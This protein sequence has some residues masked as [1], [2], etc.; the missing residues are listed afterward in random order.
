MASDGQQQTLDAIHEFRRTSYQNGYR[1]LEVY[2]PGALDRDG[3][4]IPSAG[5]RPVGRKWRE[6][7]L[8]NPPAAVVRRVS[9][10]ATNT[11]IVTGELSGLDVDV[12]NQEITDTIVAMIEATLSPTPLSRIGRAPKILLCY[13]AEQPFAKL[14]TPKYRL[15]DGTEAQL[16]ILGDGQQFVA[17]GIHPDTGQPFEWPDR[18]PLDVPLA[19]LP[20]ISAMQ[21]RDIV[22]HATSILIEAGGIIDKPES[23][24]SHGGRS[25]ESGQ[26]FRAVNDAALADIV[27]WAPSLGFHDRGGNSGWR[28]TSKELGR[29]L[30]ED[31]SIHPTGIWDFG[32]EKPL[33]AID[34]V[35]AHGGAADAVQA[36]MWLCERLGKDPESLGWKLAKGPAPAPDGRPG[37]AGAPGPSFR[38]PWEQLTPP[39]WPGG[40]LPTRFE[41][42]IA[43]M[44]E[45]SGIDPGAVGIAALLA[46]SGAAPKNCRL[47]PYGDNHSFVVP[48]IL[49]AM[50]VAPSGQRK[51]YLNDVFVA[52][53]HHRDEAW[54]QY[55]TQLADWN[56]L[57][58]QSKK[59]TPKPREP[60]A[61]LVQDITPEKM[62]RMLA[63][64]DRGTLLQRDELAAFFGFGR[65]ANDR[66]TYERSLYLE[67]YDGNQLL[68]QRLTHDAAYVRHCAVA[69][70]GSIQP[71]RLQKLNIDALGEDGLLQRFIVIMLRKA[72]ISERPGTN[73]HVTIPGRAEFNK[74]VGKLLDLG[75]L[76]GREFSATREGAEIVYRLEALGIALGD[77]TDYGPVFPEFCAKL[78]GTA[79]RLAFVLHMLDNPDAGMKIV[80]PETIARADRL[81][82]EYVLPHAR[83]F[84]AEMSE[85]GLERTRAIAAWLLA[86]APDRITASDFG[87]HV[88]L[89]RGLPLRVLNTALD[90][91]VGGGWLV[92]ESPYPGNNAWT[93][94]TQ[95]RKALAHRVADATE[96]RERNRQLAESIG[97]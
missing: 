13:R 60:F 80:M 52:L 94:D 19:A 40:I 84:Y 6:Q 76:F 27:A 5:K 59:E 16:E 11:G 88:R 58:P 69:I 10:Q 38:D 74:I 81:M 66:G 90:P 1:P 91:L 12:L 45:T 46:V 64:N 21:A 86:G 42:M 85:E 7:A 82:R 56:V 8:L 67:A 48:P 30:Q 96:Q 78:H 33:T 77:L 62:A 14:S 15:P 29:P 97:R 55:Q 35:I 65:Y 47:K 36:A 41:D 37:L 61:C 63:E 83:N 39:A 20:T 70:F 68:A 26:F 53:R 72:T 44:A 25:G 79:A 93:L 92:P 54:H 87:K 9:P 95:V 4:P 31:I 24:S 32:E 17:A 71:R 18:S 75:S 73:K 23:K 57:D 50:T 22:G 3:K 28:V 34:V 43:A 51:T 2:S 49:W 89:C